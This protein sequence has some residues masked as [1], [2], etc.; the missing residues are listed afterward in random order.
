LARDA[1]LPGRGRPPAGRENLLPYGDHAFNA[2]GPNNDLV[3]TGN[4]TGG[5]AVGVDQCTVPREALA[6]EGFGTRIWEA[7]DRGEITHEQAP[8]IVRSLLTAGVDTTVHGLA[9]VLY[10]FA[11]HPAQ[12][13]SLSDIP[14]PCQGRVR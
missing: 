6:P 1:G 8:L 7:A 14:T 4:T 5:R 9:A 13:A 12:W 10:A 3:A 2:F 11:S